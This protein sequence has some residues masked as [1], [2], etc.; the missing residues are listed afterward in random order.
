MTAS[1]KAAAGRY[2]DNRGA[3]W[4]SAPSVTL[5]TFSGTQRVTDLTGVAKWEPTVKGTLTGFAEYVNVKAIDQQTYRQAPP[6]WLPIFEAG[7]AA[8]LEGKIPEAASRFF[9]ILDLYCDDPPSS[10]FLKRCQKHLDEPALA[11]WK[12]AHVLENK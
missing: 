8:Y 12:G 7:R 3:N 5:D 11:E 2:F 10:I 1:P 6:G 9:E 4:P